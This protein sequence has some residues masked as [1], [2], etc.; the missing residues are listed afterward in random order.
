MNT[1]TTLESRHGD[2]KLK[3]CPYCGT[4]EDNLC[5]EYRDRIA[6]ICYIFCFSCGNGDCEGDAY[7][8]IVDAQDSAFIKWNR[9]PSYNLLRTLHKL[10]QFKIED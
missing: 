1:Q 4:D 10:F 5:W 7:R 3:T 8:D 6:A 9:D 2:I